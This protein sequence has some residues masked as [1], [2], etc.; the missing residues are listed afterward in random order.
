MLT[1]IS[2]GD[3]YEPSITKQ[4]FHEL[5]SLQVDPNWHGR[6]VGRQLVG[7]IANKLQREGATH[8]LVKVLVE[9]PNQGFYEHLGAIPLG[10]HPYDW[11]GYMTEELIYGWNDIKNLPN[12]H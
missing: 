8:L 2:S 7:H 1:K 4:Y 3:G 5:R 12:A 9:N 10:S 6:G 11:E